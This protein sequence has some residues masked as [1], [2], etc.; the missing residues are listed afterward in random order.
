MRFSPGERVHFAGLGTG[1]VLEARGKNRYAVAIKGRVVVAAARDLQLVDDDHRSVAQ[2]PGE[3]LTTPEV[4]GHH[5]RA[6]S[7]DLHGK[8]T[9]EAIELV[10]S[11]INDALMA[12][13]D[14]VYIIHGRGGGR[15]KAAVHRYLNQLS[16]VAAFRIDPRNPGVTVVIFA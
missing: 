8:T 16:T 11:F 9:A 6:R 3:L 12:G 2:T 4:A 5:R 7:I 10:E 14:E 15:V 1:T 13:D